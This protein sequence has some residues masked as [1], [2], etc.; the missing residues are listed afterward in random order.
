[1]NEDIKDAVRELI[2]EVD[3]LAESERNMS[4]SVFGRCPVMMR[5]RQ[6]LSQ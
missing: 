1:M 3:E 5:L 4:M 2:I 6:L